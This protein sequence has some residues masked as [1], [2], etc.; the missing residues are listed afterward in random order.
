MLVIG[1]AQSQNVKP[2]QAVKQEIASPDGIK[3]E[4]AIINVANTTGKA[5]VSKNT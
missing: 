5:V 4:D 3:I 1:V 2:E